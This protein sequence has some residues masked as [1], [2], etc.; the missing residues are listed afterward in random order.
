M[1]AL[2]FD[3][4]CAGVLAFVLAL[5]AGLV[6]LVVAAFAFGLAFA[7]G[8][9]FALLLAA[10]CFALVGELPD[11]L[12]LAVGFLLAAA[13]VL[14]AALDP[15]GDFLVVGGAMICPWFLTLLVSLKQVSRREIEGRVSYQN[16]CALTI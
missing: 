7:F 8:A 1:A 4:G 2:A 5:A 13:L 3:F 16:D 6:L 14:A 15:A 9:A 12:R 10:T 11:A